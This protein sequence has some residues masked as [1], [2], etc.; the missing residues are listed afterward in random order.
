MLLKVVIFQLEVMVYR[1]ILMWVYISQAM[2]GEKYDYNK[3]EQ[4]KLIE[5]VNAVFSTLSHL[6]EWHWEICWA[7]GNKGRKPQGISPSIDVAEKAYYEAKRL[8]D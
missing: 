3:W 6:H 4:I 1:D 8:W 5:K 7:E 2:C